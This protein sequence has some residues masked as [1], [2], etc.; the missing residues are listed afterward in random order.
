MEAQKILKIK[1][2]SEIEQSL[3]QLNVL[4]TWVKNVS[5][6]R[7]TQQ[8][9]FGLN[10][11]IVWFLMEQ[12]IKNGEKI[13]KELF[14]RIAIWHMEQKVHVKSNLVHSTFQKLG[15]DAKQL[16]DDLTAENISD[17][18]GKEFLDFLKEGVGT[19]E[20]RIYLAASKIATLIEI[21]EIKPLINEETYMKQKNELKKEVHEFLDVTGVKE[22]LI[23]GNTE[24]EFFKK[25]SM[26]RNQERWATHPYLTSCSI[27]GHLYDVAIFSWFMALDSGMSEEEAAKMFFL[28]LFHDVPE[29]YTGDMPFPNKKFLVWRFNETTGEMERV[30]LRQLTEELELAEM[31]ENAYPLF[32]AD[33]QIALQNVM[34]EDECNAKYKKLIKQADYIDADCECMRQLIAGTR[35]RYFVNVILEKAK[36]LSAGGTVLPPVTKKL[37]SKFNNYVKNLRMREFF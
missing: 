14:P 15:V 1:T 9:K 28:G 10:W 27:L 2:L 29:V 32:D 5:N 3:R 16:L 19:P 31:K 23:A 24:I 30:S 33:M 4:K 6:N 17:K 8:D 7:Y 13:R 25:L 26:L 37:F 18:V 21:D 11:L 12:S 22:L 34:F 35:D 20:E 36:Q